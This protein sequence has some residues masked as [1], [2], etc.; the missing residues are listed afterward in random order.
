M[1]KVSIIMPTYN[2]ARYIADAIKS[3]L[4]QTFKDFELIVVND[5]STDNTEE[6]VKEY[7]KKDNRI[8]YFYKPNGGVASACNFGIGKAQGE[9]ISMFEHDDISISERLDVQ[10]EKMNNNPE[11]SLVYSD[12]QT[13]DDYKGVTGT[14]G[15][16]Y[17]PI[18]AIEEFFRTLIRHGCFCNNP[19]VT[20][21]K[22]I[23]DFVKYDET[24]I[25]HGLGHDLLF[26]FQASQ[27]FIFY[28]INKPLVLWRRGHGTLSKIHDGTFKSEHIVINR[29]FKEKSI[30]FGITRKQALSM[31]YVRQARLAI[32]SKNIAN[33]YLVYFRSLINALLNNPFN[34]SIYKTLIWSFTKRILKEKI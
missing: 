30:I 10:V 17:K 24:L 31:M 3:A 13:F 20:F 22:K 6:I 29:L 26:F 12:V 8:L 34:I 33:K 9:Y 15:P 25:N 14:Y 19:S 2:G 21:R 5:G 11:I 23:W 28:H 18:M 32:M 4:N 27:Q 1:P 16:S 7:Q